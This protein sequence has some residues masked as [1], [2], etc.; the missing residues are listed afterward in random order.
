MILT[1]PL[2]TEKPPSK[3]RESRINFNFDPRLEPESL[4]RQKVKME[5]E[6]TRL[7][8]I[9]VS[10]KVLRKE[11]GFS[12]EMIH[13]FVEAFQNELGSSRSHKDE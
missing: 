3:G 10:M 12:P 11:F 1:K 5:Q 8:A 2:W 6:N 4:Y 13:D 9:K 7:E